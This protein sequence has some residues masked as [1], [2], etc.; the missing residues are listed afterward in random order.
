MIYTY[1]YNRFKPLP[2]G[3]MIKR[4]EE[5]CE[6]EK[7]EISKEALNQIIKV[8]GGIE[9]PNMFLFSSGV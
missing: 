1:I 9:V 5:I 2:E 6:A 3:P 4:L 7:L 8:S